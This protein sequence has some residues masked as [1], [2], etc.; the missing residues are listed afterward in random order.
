MKKILIVACQRRHLEIDPC[1]L[2]AGFGQ[3]SYQD[4]FLPD[5]VHIESRLVDNDN[6]RQ[7]GPELSYF[8]HAQRPHAV[9][10]FEAAPQRTCITF[11]KV[12][13]NRFSMGRDETHVLLDDEKRII[14]CTLDTDTIIKALAEKEIPAIHVQDLP[15]TDCSYVSSLIAIA[16]TKHGL[17]PTHPRFLKFPPSSA[18]FGF[19]Q[20]PLLSAE[21]C[22]NINYQDAPS[23]S[24]QTLI[25]AA[26]I[27]C[28]LA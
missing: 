9:L 7:T 2:V 25:D 3:K 4:M 20:L 15:P 22:H 16:I 5:D 28:N 12:V 8:I 26:E 23:I 19:I 17:P 14:A 27:I 6:F 13:Y 10:I 11:Q 24:R 21:V 18:R 1:E